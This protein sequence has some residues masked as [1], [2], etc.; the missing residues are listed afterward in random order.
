MAEYTF[1]CRDCK[2][3]FVTHEYQEHFPTCEVCGGRMNSKVGWGMAE[4]DY[5][6]VSESLAINPNQTQEH[7]Q[8]FPDV[9]VLPDGRLR[10]NSFRSHENYLRK[11]GFNKHP[12]KIRSKNVKS[13]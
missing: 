10:F 4:G 8:T 3:V 13:K 11:T 6:H 5:C 7:R 1:I 2:S 9:D 12:Q